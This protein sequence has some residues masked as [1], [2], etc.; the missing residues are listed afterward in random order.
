MIKSELRNRYRSIRKSLEPSIF[1]NNSRV[2]SLTLFDLI[3]TSFRFENANLTIGFYAS[4]ENEP[5]L[6]ILFKLLKDV[7]M[8]ICFPKIN[9]SYL[10]YI[11]VE[12]LGQLRPGRFG[13]LEPL[14]TIVL[15]PDVVL[16]PGVVFGRNLHRIGYGGG[17]YDR[18]LQFNNFEKKVFSIGVSHDFQIIEN[19]PYEQHDVQLDLIVSE[20]EVLRK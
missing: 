4:S 17:Y 16:I 7:G 12:D 15:T 2:I 20:L 18:F 14:G 11:L 1:E 10:N 9:S 19:V 6:E 13:I 3:K 5:S 8:Q